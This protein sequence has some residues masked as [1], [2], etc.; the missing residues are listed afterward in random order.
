[1]SAMH[2]AWSP[3]KYLLFSC[4]YSLFLLGKD[5]W[6]ACT[7]RWPRGERLATFSVCLLA[8]HAQFTAHQDGDRGGRGVGGAAYFPFHIMHLFPLLPLLEP[9]SSFISNNFIIPYQGKNQGNMTVWCNIR[10]PFHND[11]ADNTIYH[12]NPSSV[13]ARAL[14]S[15]IVYELQGVSSRAGWIQSAFQCHWTI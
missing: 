4:K 2:F 13:S 3:N 14:S 7:W 1:M 9:I 15:I 12:P 6:S 8:F 5:Q 10:F 11:S